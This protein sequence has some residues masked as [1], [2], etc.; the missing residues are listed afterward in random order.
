[1]GQLADTPE[2]N[3]LAILVVDCDE[4]RRGVYVD[5][6]SC[7]GAEPRAVATLWEALDAFEQRRPDV[8]IGDVGLPDDEGFALICELRGRGETVPA[9]AVAFGLADGM[10]AIELGYQA[11]VCKPVNWRLLGQVAEMLGKGTAFA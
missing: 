10:R 2:L 9:V 3:G 11:Y 5:L 1:M 4:D 6:L 7:F 8:V